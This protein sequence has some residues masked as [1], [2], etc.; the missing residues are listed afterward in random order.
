MLFR[1]IHE[2]TGVLA[3]HHGTAGQRYIAGL[4]NLSE[5]QRSRFA[6]KYRELVA[7]VYDYAKQRH[8]ARDTTRRV[9]NHVASME[10]AWAVF[11]ELVGLPWAKRGPFGLFSAEDLFSTF[12]QAKEA[13]KPA[14]ALDALIG[15]FA[16]N[17]KRVQYHATLPD[18]NLSTIGKVWK[19]QDGETRAAM[20]PHEVEKF[21]A[22]RGYAVDSVI[23]A[24]VE[25]G[26]FEKAPDGRR[27]W[28]V[29]IGGGDVRALVLSARY[30]QEVAEFTP[31][32]GPVDDFDL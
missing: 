12:D 22:D 32:Q 15:W 10:F 9:S 11:C 28:K 14:L 6:A 23:A 27:T 3:K 16:S 29:R 17:H 8:P 31:T 24:M 20:L 13:D 4:V 21:L 7:M 18:S 1:S 5:A 26:Y 2:T 19:T 30:S 25:K